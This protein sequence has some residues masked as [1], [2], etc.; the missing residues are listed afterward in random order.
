VGDVAAMLRTIAEAIKAD[1]ASRGIALTF[2]G[3]DEPVWTKVDA[4]RFDQIVW[5]LLSNALKFT[6][7]G[8]S[9]S[10]RLTCEED[11]LRIDVTDTGQGIEAPLL[12]HIFDMFSQGSEVRRKTG[13]MGI[14][15][16][17]VKQLVEMHA[18]SVLAQSD[19]AG[20][21]TRMSVWLPLVDGHSAGTHAP[22]ERNG[23]LAGVRMLVVDDD[24]ETASAFATLL[25][26]E[27]ALVATAHDGEDALA[28]LER[29]HVDLLVCDIGMP[30]MDGY[31]LM[32]RVRANPRLAQLPAIALTGYA[33]G[34]D[35]QRAR[36]SGFDLTLTKPVSLDAL[37]AAAEQVFFWRGAHGAGTHEHG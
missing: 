21:G 5:N 11:E 10:V 35:D 34:A 22:D 15:L 1:A 26:L 33:V 30:G 3:L 12:P 32:G 31:E 28:L 29:N 27:G 24:S 23:S 19:G 18:G 16:A 4:V 9:V 8:G 36:A 7:P 17:L 13:G 25:E 2:E 6:P 20:R 14:G 37:I